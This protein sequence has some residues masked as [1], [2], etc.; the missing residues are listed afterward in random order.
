MEKQRCAWCG[1]DPLYQA[2]HD[3]EWGVPVWDDTR[4][5]EFLT[6][7]AAQ[8]GLSW[9]TILRKREA[10]RQAYMGF[11]PKLLAGLGA[12][13]VE[14]WLQNPGLVRNRLKLEASLNNA[15]RFLEIQREFGSFAR[16]QWAFV[17]GQPLQPNRRGGDIPALTELAVA[18]ATDLKKRGFKF[19]GPVVVYAHMQACGM[20]NDHVVDCFRHSQLA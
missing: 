6:L 19:L 14:I 20:V 2:Y 18:Y 13:Q 15:R 5:F 10:Y 1:N 3:Q 11:D 4:L 12:E 9:I 8:A 7:E 16:Y 17:G